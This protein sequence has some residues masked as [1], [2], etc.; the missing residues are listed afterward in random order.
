MSWKSPEASFLAFDG[1]SIYW[2]AFFSIGVQ[3]CESH[4]ETESAKDNIFVGRQYLKSLGRLS[5]LHLP[6]VFCGQS[7]SML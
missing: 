7:N 2:A 3:F 6:L 4:E 5:E 1:V